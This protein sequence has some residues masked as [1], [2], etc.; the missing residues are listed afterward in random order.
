MHIE[1]ALCPGNNKLTQFLKEY[2]PDLVL[3]LVDSVYGQEYLN[4]SIPGTL[5]LSRIAYTGTG[6]LGR[7]INSNKFL[8]KNLLAQYGITTPKYQLMST[9]SDPVDPAL[10]YPLIAKLNEVHGTVEIDATSICDDEKQ[11]RAKVKYLISTYQQPVLIE[12]FIVGREI[13]VVILEGLNTKVY[14]AEK[15]FFQSGDPHRSFVTWEDNWGVDGSES[16]YYEKYV[17]P[18]KIKQAVKKAFD[19]LK[20]EDYA[21]FDIRLDESGR[22]YFIDCNCDPALGPKGSAAIGTVLDMYDISFEEILLRLFRNTVSDS[23][24]KSNGSHAT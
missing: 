21:K 14:S 16:F 5:E 20:M 8:T 4:A 12:E 7:A 10:D 19:I 6:M 11:L 22:H 15:V 9:T 23:Q 13:T 2:Q 1:V 18:D 24:K 17:L 3:N